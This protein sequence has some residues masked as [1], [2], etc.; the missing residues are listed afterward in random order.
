MQLIQFLTNRGTQLVMFGV[1]NSGHNWYTWSRT[2]GTQLMQFLDRGTQLV[3]PRIDGLVGFRAGVQGLEERKSLAA[4]GEME[5]RFLECPSPC[6]VTISPSC[7]GSVRIKQLAYLLVWKWNMTIRAVRLFACIQEVYI[8]NLS[9]ISA[10][11]TEI[12]V[13]FVILCKQL[14]AL[15]L[16]HRRRRNNFRFITYFNIRRHTAFRYW[17]RCKM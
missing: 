1:D 12:F 11:L 6:L 4:S 17:R 8:S 14:P 9:W 16:Q 15:E 5:P 3:L 10:T 2:L 7:P 13:T